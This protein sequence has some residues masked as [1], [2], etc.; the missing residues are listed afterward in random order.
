MSQEDASLLAKCL[1][2]IEQGARTV[3]ELATSA[4]HRGDHNRTAVMGQRE[5]DLRNLA[6]EIRDHLGMPRA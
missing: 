4:W 5:N 1:P 6:R 3:G 2:V